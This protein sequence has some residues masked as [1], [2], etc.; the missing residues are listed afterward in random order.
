MSPL[1]GV[2]RFGAIVLA[3]CSLGL[4]GATGSQAAPVEPGQSRPQGREDLSSIVLACVDKSGKLIRATIARSSGYPDIDEASL[5]V[6]R[7]AKF[8]PATTNGKP[9]RKSCVKFKVLFVLRD[10]KPVP[11]DSAGPP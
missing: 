3:A 4:A 8:A 9:R 6:A 10:G 7:A 11:A 1:R 2:P 5:K